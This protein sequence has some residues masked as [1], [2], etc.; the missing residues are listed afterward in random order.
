M[1][2][3]ATTLRAQLY[4][5]L[6]KVLATGEPVDVLRHG[7]IIRLVP[8][9]PPAKLDR[10]ESRPGVIVGDPDELI[11]LDWSDTWKP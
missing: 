10:L 5:V 1:P 2:L 6:D 11:H 4:K 3:K 9:V 7:K 8:A